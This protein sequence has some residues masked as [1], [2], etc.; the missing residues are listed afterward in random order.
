VKA[1]LE[2]SGI[3]WR[4]VVVSACYSGGFVDTLKNDETLVITASS[5]DRQSFGCGNASDATY[6]AQALFADALQ[7]TYS[8]EAAFGRAKGLIEQ[9]EG[10]KGYTASQPQIY[11]G[12]AIRAKLAEIERRLESG[13]VAGVR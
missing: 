4:V 1:A 2:E 6:L 7:N 11:V 3:R 13:K 8:F 9:W 5:A 10:E 12:N